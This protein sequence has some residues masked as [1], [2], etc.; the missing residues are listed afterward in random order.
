MMSK[1]NI[2]IKS[3]SYNNL[4]LEAAACLDPDIIDLVT[5]TKVDRTNITDERETCQCYGNKADLLR[6]SDNCL[7]ACAYCYA[8]QQDNNP[9]TYY[10]EDGTL[11]YNKYTQTSRQEEN[12]QTERIID[13]F[14]QTYD[15]AVTDGQR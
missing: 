12:Q 13:Q 4:G 5:G 6:R 15:Y 7:S 11:K 8:V 2:S 10:N 9:F 3:C 14:L 1:Y